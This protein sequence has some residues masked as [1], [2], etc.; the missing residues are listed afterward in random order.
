MQFK[1]AQTINAPVEYVFARA[2]DFA[3]FEEQSDKES[4]SFK[5][6]GRSPVRIGTR[7]DIS[8][9]YRGRKRKFTAELSQFI[10]PR[11]VSYISGNRKYQAALSLTFTPEGENSCRMEMLLVAHSRS[12]STGLVFNTIRLARKRINKGI[13]ARM[14]AVAER[15]EL[16]YAG[17]R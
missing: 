15:I 11:I 7:W 2:T 13:R 17:G 14:Q 10:A 5:R 9:P 3:K 6:I 1:H 8:V 16:D 4:L 12:F